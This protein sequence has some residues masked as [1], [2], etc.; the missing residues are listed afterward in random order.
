MA[1]GRTWLLFELHLTNFTPLPIELIGIDVLGAGASA[2]ASYRGQALDKVVIPV[3]KL[4]LPEEPPSSAANSHAIREGHSVVIF[5]DPTL[6]PGARPP[7]ELRHRFSFSVTP[8]SGGT[9]ERTVGPRR[10]TVPR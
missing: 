7:R 5:V 9:I 6:D 8:K 2:L 10:T 3:E 1:D 4:S